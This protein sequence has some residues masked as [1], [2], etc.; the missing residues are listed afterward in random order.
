MTCYKL[1][2]INSQSSFMLVVYEMMKQDILRKD[3]KFSKR[4]MDACMCK[5]IFGAGRTGVAGC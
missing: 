4:E 2:R 1:G 3:E 5:Y